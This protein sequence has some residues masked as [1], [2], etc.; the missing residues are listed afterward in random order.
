MSEHAELNLRLPPEVLA[1][2]DQIAA[3]TGRSHAD[4]AQE[5]LE[6]YLD[7]QGWQIESIRE[8]IAEADRGELGVPHARVAEW[9][10]SWGTG[11]ER[12]SPDP[13]KQRAMRIVWRPQALDDPL[14]R[15]RPF[16]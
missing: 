5:A 10:E 9:L 11:D 15:I 13:S 7:V 16:T 6:Q 14:P 2:L 12:P 8:A 4:F 3:A 1:H